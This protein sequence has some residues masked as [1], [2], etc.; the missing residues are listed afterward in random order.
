MTHDQD[1]R[2][3][4][5]WRWLPATYTVTREWLNQHRTPRGGWTAAQLRLLGVPWPPVRGWV[6][7]V[8]GQPLTVETREAFERV[9]KRGDRG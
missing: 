4:M 6:A 1:P 9:S 7:T 5:L 3:A 2:D 8:I